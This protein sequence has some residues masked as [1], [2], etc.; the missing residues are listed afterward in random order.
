MGGFS[1]G[2]DWWGGEHIVGGVLPL[3]DIGTWDLCD[4]LCLVLVCRGRYGLGVLLFIL[5]SSLGGVGPV[6]KNGKARRCAPW[7][8]HSTSN[9]CV[10]VPICIYVIMRHSLKYITMHTHT[11]THTYE[12]V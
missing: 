6:K 10:F 3:I 11:H 4:R 7:L 9:M 2:R 1:V 8:G 5:G 12:T